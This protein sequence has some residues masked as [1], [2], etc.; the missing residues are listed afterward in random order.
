MTKKNKIP[1]N[2]KT[3]NGLTL[4]LGA[5]NTKTDPEIQNKSQPLFS[6]GY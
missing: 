2:H 6:L 1:E 5:L 3:L 4:Y